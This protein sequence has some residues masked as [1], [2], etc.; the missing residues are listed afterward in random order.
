MGYERG[1]RPPFQNPSLKGHDPPAR[2]TASL[3]FETPSTPPPCTS[4]CH[5]KE[6][7]EKTMD[8]MT[9]TLKTLLLEFKSRRD[10]KPNIKPHSG[11]QTPKLVLSPG[12]THVP[13]DSP[14]VDMG[15][16]D[17]VPP[18]ARLRAAGRHNPQTSTVTARVGGSAS[19]ASCVYRWGN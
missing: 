8:I 1:P 7:L 3:P 11:N 12:R 15:D 18:A 10:K 17:P 13:T 2:I 19:P 16:P 4:G 9:T 6:K 5:S 14:S